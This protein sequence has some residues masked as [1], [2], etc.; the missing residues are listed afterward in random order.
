M[1][2]YTPSLALRNAIDRIKNPPLVLTKNKI[3]YTKFEHHAATWA[4]TKLKEIFQDERWAIT[5]EQK[6]PMTGK[7]PDLVVEEAFQGSILVLHIGMELKKEDERLEDALVQLRDALLETVDRK[8]NT[9][10]SRFEIFAVVQA[11]LDIGFFEFHSD[12]D[13]LDEEG[14]P[15]FRGC[16]SLTQDYAI[17]GTMT[18]VLPNKP[19]DLENLFYNFQNLRID[20][21][22]RRDASKYLVPCIFNIERHQEEVHFLFQHMEKH[23]PR[24]SW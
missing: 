4:C 7:K 12:Q 18:S 5:P 9:N 6:D 8:G 2:A 13:N 19:N 16:V 1:N 23:S 10:N 22:V 24:S 21:E 15:H 14:I 20:T 17:N 11:G 3:V